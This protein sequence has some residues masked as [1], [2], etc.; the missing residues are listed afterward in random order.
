MHHSDNKYVCVSIP[1]CDW[2][3]ICTNFNDLRS[4]EHD[5]MAISILRLRISTGNNN[6]SMR[7]SI[8]SQLIIHAPNVSILYVRRVYHLIGDMWLQHN[9]DYEVICV[10][11][12]IHPCAIQFTRYEQSLSIFL[13]LDFIWV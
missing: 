7:I 1:V 2:R 8:L 9:R 3:L 13:S 10:I 11:R 5:A 12:D 6:T 4:Y